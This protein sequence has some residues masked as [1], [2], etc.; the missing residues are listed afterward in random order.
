MSGNEF[1]RNEPL[2]WNVPGESEEERQ[3]GASVSRSR[4]GRWA[5]GIRW[6][7]V[8]LVGEKV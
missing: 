2:S 3:S 7:W 5:L 8:P 1:S 4:F 6:N